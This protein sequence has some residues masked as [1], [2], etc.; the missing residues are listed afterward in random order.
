MHVRHCEYS[1]CRY[2]LI[3]PGHNSF[4]CDWE[5]NKRDKEQHE[6]AVP[7]LEVY[8]KLNKAVAIIRSEHNRCNELEAQLGK[9]NDELIRLGP[10]LVIETVPTILDDAV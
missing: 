8:E 9:L 6:C 2:R 7:N 3:G 1:T 10:P 4:G 5:G